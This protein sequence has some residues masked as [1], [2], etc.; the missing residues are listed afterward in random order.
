[1]NGIRKGE[2]P[3]QVTVSPDI[4]MKHPSLVWLHKSVK[5]LLFKRGVICCMGA[6][7]RIFCEQGKIQ[8]DYCECSLR[9]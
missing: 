1:M 6:G 5:P 4:T 2:D 3:L 8:A 9:V 7:L